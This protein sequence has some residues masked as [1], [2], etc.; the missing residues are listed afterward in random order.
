MM[1]MLMM[2]VGQAFAV[3]VKVCADYLLNLS[4]AS[5]DV[6]D[7]HITSNAPRNAKGVRIRIKEE[8][9]GQLKRY[10]GHDFEYS[11]GSG[12]RTRTSSRPSLP[13]ARSSRSRKAAMSS[14][15]ARVSMK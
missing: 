9:A 11:P 12:A 4:D 7:D 14:S 5:P 2:L 10:V 6:G 1:G 13:P 8:A 3:D 15:L